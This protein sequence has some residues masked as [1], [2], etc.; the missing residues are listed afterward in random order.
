MASLFGGKGQH[1]NKE[2]ISLSLKPFSRPVYIAGK[3]LKMLE[4]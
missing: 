1:V 2:V 3:L 4:R